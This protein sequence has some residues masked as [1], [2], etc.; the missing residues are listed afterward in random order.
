MAIENS[1]NTVE[2]LMVSGDDGWLAFAQR[3]R[4]SSFK[5]FRIIGS[6]STASPRVSTKE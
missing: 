6:A 1:I 5:S 3:R 4:R 2:T